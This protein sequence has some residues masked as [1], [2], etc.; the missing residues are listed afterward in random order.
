MQG[1]L[2]LLFNVAIYL[3]VSSLNR[4][5][6]LFRYCPDDVWKLYTSDMIPAFQ[7]GFRFDLKVAGF[8]FLPLMIGVLL[9]FFS[10]KRISSKKILAGMNKTIKVLWPLFLFLFL[11][12]QQYYAFF[13]SHINILAFGIAEDDTRAVLASVWSDHPLIRVILILIFASFIVFKLLDI[14]SHQISKLSDHKKF[15]KYFSL[16]NFSIAFIFFAPAYVMAM[17]G[18]FSIFPLQRDD[19]NISNHPYIN[20]LV[21][22][23]FFALKE[24][25]QEK[26]NTKKLLSENEIISTYGLTSKDEA[27]KALNLT[28]ENDLFK[29][30]A[31]NPEARKKPF[32]LVFAMMESW[33]NSY[34]DFHDKNNNDLLS[35]LE[36]HLKEDYLFRNFY[37]STNATITTIEAMIFSKENKLLIWN[38]PFRFQS[39]ESSIAKPFHDKGYRTVYI[40]SGKIGWRNLSQWVKNQYFDEAYGQEEIAKRL[41]EALICQWGVFDEYA[42][43]LSREILLESKDKPTFIFIQTT[44]NHTPYEIPPHYTP[45]PTHIPHELETTLSSTQEFAERSLIGYQYSNH[46]LG[47]FISAVKENNELSENTIVAASGDHNAW[48]LIPRNSAIIPVKMQLSVPFYLR[49]PERLRKQVYYDPNR[50]GSHK[51]LQP[52]FVNLALDEARYFAMGNDLFSPQNSRT[53]FFGFNLDGKNISSNIDDDEALKKSSAYKAINQ[54]YFQ[55]EFCKNSPKWC[56]EK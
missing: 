3:V 13:Q 20:Y 8:I 48:S 42:F 26:Q 30:S 27:L 54:L 44:S 45:N 43:K 35:S 56:S 39:F 19:G 17:R 12:D 36:P 15:N 32:N 34:I 6:L 18:S 9:G 46:A 14:F 37:S 41:P 24:A 4:A 21:V 38:S 33:S 51:D 40:T 52:T 7:R 28:N 25:I 11:V 47:D 53:A 10:E 5:V 31:P 16:K 55:K 2:F 49:L 29:T 1:L 23:P 22:N 50:A